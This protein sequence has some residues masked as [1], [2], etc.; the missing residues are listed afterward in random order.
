MRSTAGRI[1]ISILAGLVTFYAIVAV[2]ALTGGANDPWFDQYRNA[3]GL[4]PLIGHALEGPP[5][6][7]DEFYGRHGSLIARCTTIS[8]WTF[9]FGI[10]Y[11]LLLFRRRRAI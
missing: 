9:L 10:L 1:I 8:F 5:I 4:A 7:E 6:V 3:F 2:A 11:F